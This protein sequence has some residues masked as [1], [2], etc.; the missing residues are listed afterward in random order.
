[1]SGKD[2][3]RLGLA[4]ERFGQEHELTIERG[5]PTLEDAFIHLMRDARDQ[6]EK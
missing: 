4:I 3:E 5:A 2:A 1:V 6:Y